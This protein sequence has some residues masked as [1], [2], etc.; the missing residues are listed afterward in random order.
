MSKN[1]VVEE[2][3]PVRRKISSQAVPWLARPSLLGV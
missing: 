3:L 2:G 1:L